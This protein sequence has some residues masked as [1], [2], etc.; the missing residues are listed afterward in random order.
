MKPNRIILIRHGESEG[1]FDK[2]IYSKTPDYALEISEIG[3]KQ[4]HEAG[5]R[6]LS[7]IKDE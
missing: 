7:V 6:L 5:K 3:I 1:N 4:C 2:S